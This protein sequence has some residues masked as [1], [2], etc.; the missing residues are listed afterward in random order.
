MAGVSE[1]ELLSLAGRIATTC[2]FAGLSL[3]DAEDIAQDVITWAVESGKVHLLLLA[4]WVAAVLRH[5]LNRFRRR[6]GL[7]HRVFV[8]A[9]ENAPHPLCSGAD[10][11]TATEARLFIERLATRSPDLE[12]RLLDL[13]TRGFRLSQAAR[14][15]G[16]SHGSEQYYLNKIRARARTL[17]STAPSGERVGAN[18]QSAGPPKRQS[19]STGRGTRPAPGRAR[20]YQAASPSREA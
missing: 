4:P 15:L 20:P 14:Q 2:V 5:F 10:E 7:E 1:R 11:P 19:Q 12:R 16:I 6:R 8:A 9:R 17:R 3:Q 13:L 18:E